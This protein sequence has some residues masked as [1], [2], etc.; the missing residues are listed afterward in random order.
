MAADIRIARWQDISPSQK[1]ETEQLT[2]PE[3]QVQYAGPTDRAVTASASDV[4]GDVQ[5]LMTLP[6]AYEKAGWADRGIRVEG[7]IGWVRLMR[8]N[9]VK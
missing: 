9:L 7:R 8:F 5:G 4:S 2:I 3:Q 1:T 6:R